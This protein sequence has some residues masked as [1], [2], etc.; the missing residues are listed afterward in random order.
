MTQQAEITR[1]DLIVTVMGSPAKAY[2]GRPDRGNM[3]HCR[4][5]QGIFF[6]HGLPLAAPDRSS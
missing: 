5:A 6:T 4:A 1:M 3:N 2:L